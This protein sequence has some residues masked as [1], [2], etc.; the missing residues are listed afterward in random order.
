MSYKT[1]YGDTVLARILTNSQKTKFEPVID[2]E[3]LV[4]ADGA[5]AARGDATQSDAGLPGLRHSLALHSENEEQ[6]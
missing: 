5:G 6:G 4:P 3:V 2:E 1:F